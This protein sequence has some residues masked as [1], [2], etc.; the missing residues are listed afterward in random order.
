MMAAQLALLVGGWA[1]PSAPQAQDS[2]QL[3]QH[4]RPSS[5]VTPESFD[6]GAGVGRKLVADGGGRLH[7]VW[8]RFDGNQVDLYYNRSDDQGASWST[9]VELAPS[10]SPAGAPNIAV[11][12]DGTLH[13]AWT[14]RR[15]GARARLFYLRSHDRGDSWDAPRDLAGD[16]AQDANAPSI[17]VDL[18]GRVHIA[19]HSG[20]TDV[21]AAAAR[22]HYLRSLD[23]GANFEAPVQLNGGSGHA[24]WPRFSVQGSSGERVAVAWRD[25]RRAPDW[26]VYVAVSNDAG[27]SFSEQ[28]VVATD[29][30]DWDPDVLVD[31]HG[32]IH[33]SY[34]TFADGS[35]EPPSVSYL[36]SSDGGAHW[37]TA[38][39]VSDSV[40]S[41]LS[42]WAP[43][44]YRG[45]L[46]LWW[47]DLRDADPP[48][49]QNHRA[50][51]ALRFST[52]GGRQWSALEFATDEGEVEVLFPS[53]AAAADGGAHVL[54]TESRAAGGLRTIRQRAR[55]PQAAPDAGKVFADGFEGPPRCR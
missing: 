8:M 28:P 16:A 25:N 1:L 48:P 14:D 37:G 47:K 11:G 27:T 38:L 24:A 19:W 9:P 43:D 44:P 40:R 15:S 50:D 39:V 35:G 32:V 36:C 31:A 17:S 45:V 51:V 30:R 3:G 21:G 20:S 10:P 34:T 54:W 52:D 41:E 13:V 5:V 4:W 42:S 55:D 18:L 33:L 7:A 26:D 46:W 22:V 53:I 2:Q 29:R 6:A 23:G 12:P 49:G